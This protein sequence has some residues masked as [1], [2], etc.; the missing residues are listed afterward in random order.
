M[1]RLRVRVRTKLSVRAK[2]ELG[3]G[4]IY[5]DIFRTREKG[6]WLG[7]WLGLG[8]YTKADVIYWRSE[9][10]NLKNRLCFE[11]QCWS[12]TH[13]EGFLVSLS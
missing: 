2:I 13:F 1:V 10:K 7:Q 4:F 11:P 9:H 5:L 12:T 8:L 3:L 6:R